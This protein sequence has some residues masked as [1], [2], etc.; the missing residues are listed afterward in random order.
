MMVFS[1]LLHGSGHNWGLGIAE[2]QN[3]SSAG[4][5]TMFIQATYTGTLLCIYI[6]TYVYIYICVYIYMYI[7]ICIY[8]YVYIYIYSICMLTF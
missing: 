7:Y 8:I 6:Y 3:Y 5:S 4:C 2:L 1:C